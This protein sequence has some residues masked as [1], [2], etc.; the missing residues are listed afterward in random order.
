M[1]FPKKKNSPLMPALKNGIMEARLKNNWHKIAY[2]FY[3]LSY[4]EY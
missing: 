2:Y 1:L 4:K 3:D